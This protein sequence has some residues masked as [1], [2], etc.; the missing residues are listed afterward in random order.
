MLARLG[1]DAADPI[2][3]FLNAA[4]DFEQAHTPSLEA[5]LHAIERRKPRS[6]AIR[7]AAKGRCA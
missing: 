7:I 6:S 4:L 3:E 5:F 2:E 1:F